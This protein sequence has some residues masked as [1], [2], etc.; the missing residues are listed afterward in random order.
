MLSYNCETNGIGYCYDKMRLN[1][2]I[3]KNELT[4]LFPRDDLKKESDQFLISKSSNKAQKF[5]LF[6]KI[7]M[8]APS[9]KCLEIINKSIP[10][11][12]M[13][14]ISKLE[15]AQDIFFETEQEALLALY[16]LLQTIRKKYTSE[17]FIY[18]QFYA[19]ESK[20]K[21]KIN[22]SHFSP[23]T[24]YFGSKYF[25]YVIYAR[26]SKINERP[27][28]H[29][30]WRIVGA[31]Q[32]KTKTGIASIHD[33]ITFDLLKFF[34]EQD[35]RYIS[36]EGIDLTKLGCWLLGWNKKKYLSKRAFMKMGINYKWRL[37]PET[38]NEAV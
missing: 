27:C 15:I 35:K 18:N 21:S 37:N 8:V 25:K 30:E 9:R 4:K 17:H 38:V 10:P 24:G 28:I 36:H 11:W 34:N 19:D 29:A 32:L 12:V 31:S 22:K 33:L 6:S 14:K 26:L 3:N 16:K 1:F 23:V 20:K 13:V 2:N 7:E 5:G